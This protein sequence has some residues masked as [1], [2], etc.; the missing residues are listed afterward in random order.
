MVTLGPNSE[1]HFYGVV[2]TGTRIR[3]T[4]RQGLGLTQSCTPIGGTAVGPGGSDD[5]VHVHV[6]LC[7]GHLINNLGL[8]RQ[9]NCRPNMASPCCRGSCQ[10]AA[11]QLSKAGLHSQGGRR[12]KQCPG[13]VILLGVL[14][15]A[16]NEMVIV[17]A[18]SSTGTIRLAA[19]APR[20][21]WAA[22][23]SL[24][25]CSSAQHCTTC[26]GKHCGLQSASKARILCGAWR[27]CPKSA[28]QLT[29]HRAPVY[30]LGRQSPSQ[31]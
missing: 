6:V 15:Q 14:R 20:H 17:P 3:E 28:L 8:E 24:V 30:G 5:D 12:T 7:G 9:R 22:G 29:R 1:N 26:A 18:Q 21:W 13:V 2:D 11:V 4:T 10:D 19:V 27:K 23:K 25:C 16:L 31:S